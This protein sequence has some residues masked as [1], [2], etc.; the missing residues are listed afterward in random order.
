MDHFKGFTGLC[1]V[2]AT[3]VVNAFFN[4]ARRGA[5]LLAAFIVLTISHSSYAQ[6]GPDAPPSDAIEETRIDDDALLDIPTKRANEL[7]ISEEE[8]GVPAP[9]GGDVQDTYQTAGLSALDE[10]LFGDSHDIDTGALSFTQIDVSLPGSSGLPVQIGRRLSRNHISYANKG[11]FGDWVPTIPSMSYNYL[12]IRKDQDGRSR[13]LCTTSIPYQRLVPNPQYNG[14]GEGFIRVPPEAPVYLNE[15][16]NGLDLNVEGG[17]RVNLISN[18]ID[19]PEFRAQSDVR[20]VNKENWIIRCIP[21]GSGYTAVSPSGRKYTF[22]KHVTFAYNYLDGVQQ[23]VDKEVIYV[24]RIEDVNGNWVNYN[25]SGDKLNSITSNDGRK[26]SLTWSGDYISAIDANGRRWS[27]NYGAP[28]FNNPR[29]GGQALKSVRQPDGQSWE[30]SRLNNGSNDFTPFPTKGVCD[31]TKNISG[32]QIKHPYGAIGQF[33]V[34]LIT[35][36]RH[37]MTDPIDGQH[38]GTGVVPSIDDETGCGG[39]L[40]GHFFAFHSIA[41]DQKTIIVSPSKTKTWK[42]E[43]E[44]P[45]GSYETAFPQDSDS[46]DGPLKT[47]TEIRPDNSRIVTHINRQ[48]GVTEGRIEKREYFGATSNTP[49]KTETMSYVYGHRLGPKNIGTR[50]LKE[51]AARLTHSYLTKTVTQQDGDTFTSERKYN[52]DPSKSDYSYGRPVETRS[53]SNVSTE[54]RIIQTEYEHNTAKWILGLPKRMLQNGREMS[55][56]AYDSFGR[57][58]SQTRYGK[59]Y[60]SFRYHTNLNYPE[61]LGALYRVTDALGRSTE[62]REYKRGVPQRIRR[63]INTA[64]ETNEYQYVDDNGWLTS[65]VDAAGKTTLYTH[66]VMGRLTQINPNGSWANTDIT[67]DFNGGGAVQTIT[68]GQARTTVTYDAMFRPRLERTQALDT[69]WSSYVNTEYDPLGRVIFTSQP[70][71]NPNEAK[72]VE[73]SYDGLGRMVERG[74]NVAPY[75][76]T[77][78]R[79]L[80][81]HRRRVID[82]SGAYTDYYSYGWDG[83]GNEDYRLIYQYAKGGGQY[84][85]RTTLRKNIYGQLTSLQQYGLSGG[86]TNSQY[87]YFIYDDEQRLCRHHV[88]EQN[89]TRY[90]YD[91]AGQMIAYAKGQG[92]SSCEVPNTDARVEM[93]YDGLGRLVETDF[94][95]AGTPDIT[96]TYDEVGNVISVTRGEGTDAVEWSYGYNSA[97]ILNAETLRLD[98]RNFRLRYNY[99]SSGHMTRRRLPSGR[100]I[101]YTPD[102]LGRVTDVESDG[103]TLAS[104]T[105]FHASGT[106]ISMDYGNG[107]EFTQTLNARLLPQRGRSVKSGVN[108]AFDQELIYDARGKITEITDRAQSVNNRTYG[109]DGLGQLIAATGP[110]GENGAS[111]AQASFTYDSLGNL[112]NKTLGPRNVI[113]SYDSRNRLTRSADA[114]A[115]DGQSTGTRTIAYDVRGNVTTLGSMGFVYDYTDQPIAVSGSAS[116][117]GKVGVNGADGA[118]TGNY[119]YDGN[120]KRVKSV[121][122]GKTI[123]NI[124]DAGGALVHVDAVSDGEETDYVSG[125]MGALARYKTQEAGSGSAATGT[126]DEITY[127]HNDHLGSAQSGTATNGVVIWRERYTPFGSEIVGVADNDNQAGFTGH[128]KDGATG[129]NYMQARYYDP[130]I[131]RFLSV[132]PVTMIQTGNPAHFNRYA[133]ANNDPVNLVDPDGRK[134]TA[135]FSPK[136]GAFFIRDNDTGAFAFSSNFFTGQSGLTSS[137]TGGPVPSGNFSILSRPGEMAGM[138][139]FRLEAIDSN[140]GDDKI[141]GGR[142][143]IRLHNGTV[144]LGCVTCRVPQD[145]IKVLDVLSNTSTSKTSVDRKG[146][147]GM[148]GGK[149]TLTNF[150]ELT[151]LG[152]NSSLNFNAK[153]GDVSITTHTTRTG[154]RIRRRETRTLCT[155]GDDGGCK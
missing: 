141:N 26:I 106:V 8:A 139:A 41:L 94:N 85:R 34:K 103:D 100:N 152:E 107:H 78:Y 93:S 137:Q 51:F 1:Q 11:G 113:L 58:T 82:P 27:Y 89:S 112:L 35:N 74:E 20:S 151:V 46:T 116:L 129:L 47:R 39:F 42:W 115:P 117:S 45:S 2:F 24:S 57:K 30:F 97:D 59:L 68:K 147:G 105:R 148:I 72:G 31:A 32:V 36:S 12:A 134:A 83:P 61:N 92:S 77:G 111:R 56:Y 76:P 138:Q 53:Y 122:N 18:S 109:Y 17:Q 25:Y 23:G 108:P 96:R 149:E 143:L 50:T 81:N 62:L 87:Q 63:A 123:Y 88:P 126:Q 146:L 64:D 135:H 86:V 142:E 52:M 3:Y 6:E 125:P 5:A 118:T 102:G 136:N 110:W 60:G 15:Y 22:N 99:N 153:T 4:G 49:L 66:D 154:S 73:S 65:Q 9:S 119:R 145:F 21:G 150:G 10:S 155:V 79:Y 144:S 55:S 114:G 84:L 40:A 127:I 33:K 128:I 98:G 104:G 91:A 95:H 133:Y 38:Y 90:E 80:S 43:Y 54:P 130:V 75:A 37:L 29:L 48:Y 28:H 44:E 69:G 71:T 121:V 131:G 13:N 67:Y 140:F 19:S 16:N 70:S 7:G 132:D 14:T 120:L 101:D 124:Y